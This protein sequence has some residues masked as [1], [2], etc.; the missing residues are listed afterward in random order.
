[1]ARFILLGAGAG[2]VSAALFASAATGT[3]LAGILF[4]LAPLPICLAGLGW[5]WTNL[6]TSISSCTP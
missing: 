6:R 5:G 1:M 3:A 4:Y 2:L